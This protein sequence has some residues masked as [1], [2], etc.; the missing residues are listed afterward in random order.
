MT[1]ESKLDESIRKKLSDFPR[2]L[3]VFNKLCSDDEFNRLVDFA[4]FVSVKKLGFNDH[5]IVHA[6]ITLDSALKFFS[7]LKGVSGVERA[8]DSLDDSYC[9]IVLGSLLHD[10][11]MSINRKNH[12]EL[13]V[14][15]ARPIMERILSS[16][17]NK[18]IIISVACQ[19]ILGHMGGYDC[20]FAESGV[21]ALG[22]GTDM[23]GGRARI[24]YTLETFK[25]SRKIHTYSALSIYNVEISE[26]EDK[27]VLV[28][29]MMNNPAGVF[30]IEENFLPKVIGSSLGNFLSIVAL[31]NE[32]DGEERIFIF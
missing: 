29:V 7:I 16:I 10:I 8:F 14:V 6:K 20:Y 2:A 30:Q 21:V 11:G 25:K 12:E 28:R 24:P 27:P 22:D 32:D 13:G 18:G 15:I 9:C 23:T 26:G 31:V 4:N 17:H 5:G 1:K 3:N 19:S